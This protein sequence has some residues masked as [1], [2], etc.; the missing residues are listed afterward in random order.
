MNICEHLT[1]TGRN[2]VHINQSRKDYDE[3]PSVH[4]GQ[5]LDAPEYI[6][7]GFVFYAE[8]CNRALTGIVYREHAYCGY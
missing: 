7:N 1:T 8:N 2:A 5:A 6:A 4:E 3:W